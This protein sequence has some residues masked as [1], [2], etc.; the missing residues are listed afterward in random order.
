MFRCARGHW[1][2]LGEKMTRIA[3][4]RRER[5]YPE[6]GTGWEA[7]REESLCPEHALEHERSIEAET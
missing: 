5:I 6:G 4:E 1:S 2:N 7:V 3:S